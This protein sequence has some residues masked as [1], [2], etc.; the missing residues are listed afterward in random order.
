MS[1][2]IG[3][4]VSF[5]IDFIVPISGKIF[6]EDPISSVYMKLQTDSEILSVC[7]QLHVNATDRI[8]VKFYQRY[9]CGRQK[10]WLNFGCHPP[11]SAV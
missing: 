8:F 11:I 5:F 2:I 7:L 6:H 4:S 1:W 3:Q 9:T 10:N